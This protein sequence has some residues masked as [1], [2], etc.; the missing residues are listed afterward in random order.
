MAA[1]TI[2]IAAWLDRYLAVAMSAL[3]P[4]PAR[5]I[6]QPG[7]EVAWDECCDGQG[8]SRLIGVIPVLGANRANGMPCGIQWWNLQLAVGVIRC[9]HVV[10]DNGVAPSAAQITADGDQ[11]ATDVSDLLQAI[12]CDKYTYAVTGI[13][14][15]GPQGGCAG[16]EVQF[17]VRVNACGCP[18]EGEG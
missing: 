12:V 1:S 5:Q 14:P 3:D 7:L 17:T 9:V 18:P 13:T 15:L 16:S 11:F 8:W 6:V 10:D 4:A 2:N